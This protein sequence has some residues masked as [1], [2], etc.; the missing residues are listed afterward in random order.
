MRQH[1]LYARLLNIDVFL[2]FGRGWMPQLNFVPRL[3]IFW[4]CFCFSLMWYLVYSSRG[5]H[6]AVSFCCYWGFE[7]RGSGHERRRCDWLGNL[8]LYKYARCYVSRQYPPLCTYARSCLTNSLTSL[9]LDVVFHHFWHL[10]ASQPLFGK[11]DETARQL[12]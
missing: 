11:R 1:Q 2:T 10:R 6:A 5:A 7:C 12:Q 8:V 3:C 9:G 4:P